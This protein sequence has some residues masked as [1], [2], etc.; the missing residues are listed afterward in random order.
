M[1]CG[2]SP[3]IE[4]SLARPRPLRVTMTL[5]KMA[6]DTSP[7]GTDG[8]LARAAEFSVGGA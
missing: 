8:P 7:E 2:N 1:A 6:C 3:D 4:K 5:V